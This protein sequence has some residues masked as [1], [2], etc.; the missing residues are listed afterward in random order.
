M[1]T[2]E[3]MALWLRESIEAVTLTVKDED[4]SIFRTF[5]VKWYHKGVYDI[6][7]AH[8]PDDHVLMASVMKMAITMNDI[9]RPIKKKAAKWLTDNGFSKEI[10]L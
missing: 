3:L 1:K 10:R 6:E 2:R 8:L 9:S 4:I 5:Y 7:P